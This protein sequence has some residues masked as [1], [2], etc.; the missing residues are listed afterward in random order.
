MSVQILMLAGREALVLPR[1]LFRPLLDAYRGK[2]DHLVFAVRSADGSSGGPKQ[3]HASEEDVEA[4]V[5]EH[6]DS[7]YRLA[8]SLVRD[9]AL[10][11]DVVQEALIK[12]WRALPSFRGDSSLRRWI[13]TIT[14]NTAVS[15]LRTA[16]EEAHDPGK[17]PDSP[18]PSSLEKSVQ[19]KLAVDQVWKALGELDESSRA[20]IVLRDVE[21][22]SYEE[23]CGVMGLPLSTIRTRLFRVRRTLAGALEDWRP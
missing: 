13:L 17:L 6:V 14:H 15:L 21:G 5:V 11:E 1:G 3:V 7:I 16:R 2:F 19:D 22:L 4:L 8:L 10:A 20:L 9:P 18:M 12:A 23:I